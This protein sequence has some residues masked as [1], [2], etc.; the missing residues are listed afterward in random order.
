MT[1]PYSISDSQLERFRNN[2]SEL[3]LKLGST[4]YKLSG[5]FCPDIEWESPRDRDAVLTELAEIEKAI[6]AFKPASIQSPLRPEILYSFGKSQEVRKL[7]LR[8]LAF[9]CFTTLYREIS[10]ISIMSLARAVSPESRELIQALE[11]RRLIS[12]MVLQNAVRLDKQAFEGHPLVPSIRV[13]TRFL[14]QLLGSDKCMAV[15]TPKVVE[16][17]R[18]EKQEKILDAIDKDKA[19][20]KAPCLQ[21]KPITLPPDRFRNWKQR[22]DGGVL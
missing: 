10:Q 8:I 18:A 1:L 19:L 11:V 7:C 3:F 6:D 17:I 14:I 16:A 12:H 4:L 9:L 22:P 21:Q 20:K 2:G 5:G 15:L 13:N